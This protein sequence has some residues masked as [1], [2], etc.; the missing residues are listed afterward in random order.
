MKTRRLSLL[1]GLLF[2]LSIV[3]TACAGAGDGGPRQP[4]SYDVQQ[5]SIRF[6]GERY[7]LFWADQSGTLHEMQTRKLRLVRD[8]DRTYLEV[9]GSGDPIL[10]LKEDAPITVEGQDREGGFSSSWF[11][12]FL[13]TALGSQLGGNRGGTVIINQPA[14]GERSY[15]AGTPAYRY[16]PTGSFGRDEDLH[17][18]V[19][20]SKPTPPDYA[21]VQPQPYAT[22]GK[23]SGTGGGTAASNKAPSTSSQVGAG[24]GNANATS[25]QGGG[26]GAG[27]AASSKGGFRSGD[28]SFSNSSRSSGSSSVGAGSSGALS[29][30]GSSGSVS[31]K[32]STG[33]SGS[34]PTGGSGSSGSKGIGGARVGG[35]RR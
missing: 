22:S 23:S 21:K 26:T 8:P 32:P 12:F 11:P 24:S 16:P 10:H 30:G 15:D 25:G 34:K 27:T 3:S 19:D 1:V 2:L 33:V 13:G 20:S 9:P 14:P 31:G 6:D 4:G 5:N 7:D 35:G 28:Q 29:G 18:S 17:G